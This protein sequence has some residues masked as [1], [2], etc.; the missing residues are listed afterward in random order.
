M[1]KGKLYIVSGPS[2][3]GKD[4]L[5]ERCM[6]QN[7]NIVLSVSA[8]TRQI[9]KGEQDG[10]HYYFL[11]TD[12][13]EDMIAKGELLEWAKYCENYYGTPLEPINRNLEKGINVVLNI[14]VQGA[15][16]VMEKL[17]TAVSVFIMPPSLEI[18]EQRLRNRGTDSDEAIAKRLLTAQSEMALAEKYSYTVINDDL[19]TAVKELSDIINK[20]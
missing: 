17:P 20:K 10:V 15:M 3:S 2:G 16:Q 1:S 13:F 7:D 11:S 18:L 19:N 4:T 5:I 9:R 12:K 6:Q 14:E 8:T